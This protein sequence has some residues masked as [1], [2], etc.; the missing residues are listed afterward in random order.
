MK[1]KQDDVFLKGEGD[2]W[3]SRN[4]E[5]L[6]E[7]S[8]TF[9]WPT[10]L[11]ELIDDK[12]NIKTIAE[13]GCSNGWRLNKLQNIYPHVEFSGI[14]PSLEA[15]EDGKKKYP[16][17]EL[18]KGVLADIPLREEFDIVIVYFV[19]CWVD[20]Y[21][22]AK[23]IAEVDRLVKDGGMLI[24]GDFYPD[25]PQRRL[26]HH[27]AEENIFTY[28]QKYAGIFESLGTYK[29]ITRCTSVNDTRQSVSIQT[30]DSS[31]R[32]SC[33]VLHKSLTNYYCES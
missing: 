30:C 26:Y 16:K 14:D 11:I 7:K 5:G 29:E 1:S 4:A 22:L 13:L 20:R 9:D 12:S 23:S 17:I 32:L 21:S 28:K 31:N 24:I 27:L 3:F 2:S 10:Y 6:D 8:E 19:L 15:I 18:Q 33:S 25:Y